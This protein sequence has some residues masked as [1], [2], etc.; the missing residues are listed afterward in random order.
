MGSEMCI[1]D[2]RIDA[3]GTTLWQKNGVPVCDAGKEQ[4]TPR[5][6]S[7]GVGSAIVVWS[8][9]RGGDYDIYIHRV[10]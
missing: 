10:Q 2:R 8:D 9:A 5:A 6:V 3:N 7:A 1:R 4:I